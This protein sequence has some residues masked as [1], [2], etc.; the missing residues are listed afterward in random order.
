MWAARSSRHGIRIICSSQNYRQDAV[1]CGVTLQPITRWWLEA[2]QTRADELDHPQA[3]LVGHFAPLLARGG[4]VVLGEKAVPTQ[5]ET[6]HR[7]V[8]P[9]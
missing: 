7:W 3:G 4:C 1:G 8:L 2:A 5:A 9:A 6:I